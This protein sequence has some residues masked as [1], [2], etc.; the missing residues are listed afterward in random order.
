LT[1][2]V[3]IALLATAGCTTTV[4]TTS[5][6]AP[7]T[8]TVTG[9]GTGSSAPDRATLSMSVNAHARS[10]SDAMNS[11]TKA[12]DRLVVALKAAGLSDAELQTQQVSV[13]Q[14]GG[15]RGSSYQAN[16]A[17]KITTKQLD[18]LG[19]FV[20]EATRA[21]ASGI[22]GPDFSLVDQRSVQA[23]AIA[24]AMKDARTRAS[25]MAKSAGRGLGR[26]VSV[27]D[28]TRS[29]SSSP[30]SNNLV[31]GLGAGVSFQY[32]AAQKATI[33]PNVS[34]GRV[35]ASAQMTVVFAL[36]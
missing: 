2:V 13:Y 9:S 6:A 10:S 18:M 20:A 27:S 3:L 22:S 12:M 35:T 34:P 7:D 24:A 11:A 15:P 5:A 4:V 29:S 14:Q 28:V 32:L 33:A 17:L 25:V 31:G 19:K 21:G 26:V 30:Y 36:Q 23:R 1:A 8:V 16:Q